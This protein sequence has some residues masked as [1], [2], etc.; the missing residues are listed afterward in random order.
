MQQQFYL[1]SHEITPLTL[2]I[3]AR[4][5]NKQLSTC[6]LEEDGEYTVRQAPSKLVDNACRYFGSS[7]KGRQDGTKEVCGI[8]HKAPISIDPLS[9]MYFFPTYSPQSPKCSWIA[10]SHI[11]EMHKATSTLSE[12]IFKNGKRAM[13]EVSYGSLLNQVQRTAQ[14]R[15]LLDHRINFLQQLRKDSD[16]EPFS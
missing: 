13:I 6:V 16:P 15:F 10:H 2:A 8:T 5:D 3:V 4:K 14:F 11:D 9:G 12:I 1:P 7:L